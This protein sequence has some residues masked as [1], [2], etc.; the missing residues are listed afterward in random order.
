MFSSM[1]RGA[2]KALRMAFAVQVGC[3]EDFGGGL[4]GGTEVGDDFAAAVGDFVGRFEVVVDVDV[5]ALGRDVTDVT[6]GGFD[7]VAGAEVLVDGFGFGGGFDDD[8][9]L[10]AAA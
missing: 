10:A 9:S 8:E 1:R 2:L 5:E 4:G 6:D 3:E 7:G